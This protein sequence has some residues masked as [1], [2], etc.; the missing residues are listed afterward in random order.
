MRLNIKNI[1]LIGDASIDFD[2]ITVLAGENG[3]GKSTV[4]L[5]LYTIFKSLYKLEENAYDTL[6][7]KIKNTIRKVNVNQFSVNS[8]VYNS[9]ILQLLNMYKYKKTSIDDFLHFFDYLSINKI[10]FQEDEKTYVIDTLKDI[11]SVDINNYMME[12]INKHART[13]FGRDIYNVNLTN[14]KS[15]L[16]LFLKHDGDLYKYENRISFVDNSIDSFFVEL[17]INYDTLYYNGFDDNIFLNIKIMQSINE[18]RISKYNKRDVF[19]LNLLF[20]DINSN[21][22]FCKNIDLC[23]QIFKQFGQ[24]GKIFYDKG[25]LYYRD[26]TLNKNIEVCKISSGLKSIMILR[27]LVLTGNLSNRMVLILDEPE[28][29]LHP[30]WQIYLAEVI[31]LMQLKLDLTI[32]ISS[33]SPDFIRAIELFS[34]KN[35]I[36][37]RLNFY[38]TTLVENNIANIKKVDS[39]NE[40]YYSLY[41]P[42]EEMEGLS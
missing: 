32:L 39:A 22:S 23:N 27:Q 9:I 4:S 19:N 41:K 36:I 11:F 10:G 5:S 6:V 31:C 14:T 26:N 42:I 3:S 16:S 34:K 28:I 13:N 37:D 35:N 40:I 38:H 7:L 21:N 17:P 1:G 30:K 15:E 8:D 18:L 2:G 20:D 33:H 24:L 25:R 29:N 12:E